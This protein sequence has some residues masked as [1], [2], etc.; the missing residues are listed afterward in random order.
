MSGAR[1]LNPHG[2]DLTVAPVELSESILDEARRLDDPA[3]CARL[4]SLAGQLQGLAFG[5]IE[6]DTARI[7]FWANIYNA[8]LLHRV[9]L[10]PVSGNMLWH[11]RL[12]G[13]T[14]YRIGGELFTLNQI[15]HGVL[16]RNRRPPY[17]LRKPFRRS[18]RRLAASPAE[19]DPRIHFAL[20]C[21]A[22]S[23]PPINHYDSEHLDQQLELATRSYLDSE[24]AFDPARGPVKL[25]RLMRLY[26]GD[27]GSRAQQL[28]FAAARLPRLRERLSR[29]QSRGPRVRYGRFDWTAVANSG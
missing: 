3:E 26:R 11:L 15:E 4:D 2:R 7:A 12:F 18:D 21:G 10:K 17:Q 24:T 14:A 8:L 19:V 23:C 13:G 20:N 16:R 6:G 29:A 28:E 25:P 1:I 9:C 22:R 27:F 5:E